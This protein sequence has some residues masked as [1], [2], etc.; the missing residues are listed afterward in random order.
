LFTFDELSNQLA[1]ASVG[2]TVG[3]VVVNLLIFVEDICV[4]G[5]SISP[6]QCLLIICGEYAAEYEIAKCNKTN[7][8]LFAPKRIYHR[9]H[10]MFS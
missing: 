10:Q 8:V 3:N 9:L 2:Y 6:L 7:G 1:S 5:S 4:L